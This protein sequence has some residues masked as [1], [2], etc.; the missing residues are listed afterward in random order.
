MQVLFPR[1]PTSYG[2][3]ICMGI[4]ASAQ[5]PHANAC[6][7]DHSITAVSFLSHPRAA[8]LLLAERSEQWCWHSAVGVHSINRRGGKCQKTSRKEAVK[9]LSPLTVLFCLFPQLL[10]T[11]EIQSVTLILSSHLLI[12]LIISSQTF[13][14]FPK[15]KGRG[16]KQNPNFLALQDA[17]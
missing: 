17:T 16:T 2:G 10:P 5:L 3:C 8:A 12:L 4:G 11:A 13:S 14:P 9:G 15:E 7:I 6:C 1:Y